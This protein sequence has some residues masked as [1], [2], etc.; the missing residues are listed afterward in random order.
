MLSQLLRR[1]HYLAWLLCAGA[2]LAQPRPLLPPALART[3]PAQAL[4]QDFDLFRSLY[5]AANPSLYQYRSRQQLDSAF[6]AARRGLTD[7]TTLLGFYGLLYGITAYTGSLHSDNYLPAKADSALLA[8]TGFFPYPVQLL[9]GRLR[10]NTQ[11]APPPLGSELVRVNG[12]AV[13]ELRTRL[14]IFA[15]TDGY[16]QTGKDYLLSTHFAR[17]YYLAY[18][19]CATFR[20]TYRQP[21]HADT[22]QLVVAA[23]PYATYAQRYEQRHSAPLETEL[24]PYQLAFIDSLRT[25]LLTVNTFELG[26]PD[27]LS[28]QRYARFLDSAFRELRSRPTVRRLIL[29]VRRNSGGDDPN[30]MLLFS[31]LATH[32]YRENRRAFASFRQ[33]PYPAYFVEDTLGDRAELEQTLADEHGPARRGRYW[34]K[35]QERPYWH[36]SPLAFRGQVYLLVG[37]AVA[38]AGSLFASLVRSQRGPIVLGQETMGG[39]YGHTGHT[40]VTY[41]LPNTHIRVKFSIIALE[42]D[43]RRRRRF[44]KGRGVMPDYEVTPDLADFLTNQDATLRATLRLIQ[45]QLPH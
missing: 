11:A 1:W 15:T 34:L 45:Q 9:A 36:P 40:P 7:S 37:P 5:E 18:G 39:Y 41:E 16:N 44:P 2:A 30:D 35:P 23:V 8:S 26:S 42:Q 38:S 31:Y 17:Y 3:V 6:A 14:G 25:A 20:L 43:V 4:R 22:A 33:V 19:P 32:R 13:T 21:Y 24:P 27:E 29:D 28:H 10:L 12:H